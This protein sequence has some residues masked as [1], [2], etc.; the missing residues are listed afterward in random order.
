EGVQHMDILT[1][2]LFNRVMAQLGLCAFRAGL[3][4]EAHGCLSELYSGG[5]NLQHT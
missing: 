4:K 5:Y 2:M 3:T 1:Q